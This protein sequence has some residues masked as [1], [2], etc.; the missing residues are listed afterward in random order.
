VS[1]TSPAISRHYGTAA[2]QDHG[3]DDNAN[4]FFEGAWNHFLADSCVVSLGQ[5]HHSATRIIDLGGVHDQPALWPRLPSLGPLYLYI[6][7]IAWRT[8]RWRRL[9]RVIGGPGGFGFAI[10]LRQLRI[11]SPIVK[12][13]AAAPPSLRL[14]GADYARRTSLD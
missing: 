5:R 7:A 14:V 4:D 9:P 11:V 1:I 12:R 2:Q 6:S 13:Q 3:S 8:P 10:C